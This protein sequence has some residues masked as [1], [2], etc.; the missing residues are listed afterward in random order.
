MSLFGKLQTIDALQLL[1][2]NFP[3]DEVYSNLRNDLAKFLFY[4]PQV[5]CLA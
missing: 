3:S 5:S 4:N 1:A 2:T